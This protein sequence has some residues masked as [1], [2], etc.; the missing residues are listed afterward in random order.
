MGKQNWIKELTGYLNAQNADDID[1]IISE[2][3]EHFARK[4]ADGYSEEE[5]AIKLGNPKDIAAQY[6]QM[7]EK[8]EKRKSNKVLV[9]TGLFFAD[10]FTVPF[11]V[12]MYAWIAVLGAASIA[13]GAYGVC[14]MVKP[15][16]WFDSIIFPPIPYI[17]GLIWG[18]MMIAFG[19]LAAAVMLYCCA[20][21]VQMGRA[22]ARWHKN[23]MN[24]GKY[25]PYSMHPMMKD[26]LRRRLR[27]VSLIALI[28]F[29]ATFIIGFVVLAASAGALGFWHVWNWFV[30]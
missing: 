26:R 16:L 11:F 4:A 28:V 17:G 27:S 20:L 25:P 8:A 3:D 15:V 21:T 6:V 12:V 13:T 2:Y 23:A 18:V 24:D 19:V 5:I 7:K 14:L 9:G 10:L 1:E 29:G 30:P 22:Y